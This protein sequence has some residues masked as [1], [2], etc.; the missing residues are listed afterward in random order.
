MTKMD[1]DKDDSEHLEKISDFKTYAKVNKV[2][3]LKQQWLCSLLLLRTTGLNGCGISVCHSQ[4]A[5]TCISTC[6]VQGSC[7]WTPDL[8]LGSPGDCLHPT[9]GG[10]HGCAKELQCKKKVCRI[11]VTD[12]F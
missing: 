6:G 2:Y 8:L 7:H 3:W 12:A 11:S 4:P 9:V 1:N 10:T 5:E